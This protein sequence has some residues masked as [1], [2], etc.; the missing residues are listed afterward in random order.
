MLLL[1]MC[2]PSLLVGEI[3]CGNYSLLFTTVL[4]NNDNVCAITAGWI[5]YLRRLYCTVYCLLL[6]YNNVC[7][8]A[9][10]RIK[11]CDC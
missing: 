11:Y 6:C 4:L 7:A 1:I 9:A 5:K 2:K 10:V 8:V 3:I